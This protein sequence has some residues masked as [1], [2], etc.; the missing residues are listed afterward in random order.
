LLIV[1][2]AAGFAGCARRV[3][4][5]P[6]PGPADPRVERIDR[7]LSAAAKYLLDIQG[8]DGAWRSDTYGPFKDGASLTPW[9]LHALQGCPPSPRLQ[10]A[11]RKGV[12]YLAGMARSDGSIDEG[13]FGLSYPVYT[14]AGAV[15]VL[16]RETDTGQ[17][18]ARDAWLA[19]LRR[20]QLTEELGW[21][22]ADKE[23]GGWGYSSR[24]P[25][26]PKEEELTESNLSATV[27][28]LEALRAGGCPTTDPAFS[29]A[30]TFVQRCQNFSDDPKRRDPAF[31]DGGF[32]FIYDDPARNKAGVAGT[33]KGGRERFASYGSATADGLRC[34]VYCG[35]GPDHPRVAA[36]RRWL[37]RHFSATR[38]PGNFAED[39]EGKR[40]AV[41]YYYAWSAAKALRATAGPTIRTDQA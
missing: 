23:Y 4:D 40:P 11:C 13:E 21:Q 6:G 17:G 15:I 30:L 27:F 10:E 7:S 12:R 37:E 35:L 25:R 8:Q 39:R 41:Y 34:L 9:V 22:P 3:A 38:H 20:R 29:K 36:A 2:A 14:A 28:A 33:D 31:D 18:K 16:S 5:P 19:Y 1:L 32:F 24:L 26:K